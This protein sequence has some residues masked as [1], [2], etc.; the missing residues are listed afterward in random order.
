MPPVNIS[1]A[2]AVD[3]GSIPVDVTQN[4]I[5]DAGVNY[6]VY[7]KFTAPVGAQVIGAWGFSGNTSS[8]Y[9]P[10]IKPYLGPAGAPTQLLNIDCQNKPI[11]FP[12]DVGQEYFLEFV[13]NLD[14]AGPNSLRVRLEI[15][16]NDAVEV[17]NIIVNDDGLKA[18][19]FPCGIFSHLINHT[20][21]R[22]FKN[23]AEGEGGDILRTAPSLGVMA[24]ENHH[25]DTIRIYDANF[26]QTG[27]VSAGVSLNRPRIRTVL[28]TNRWAVADQGGPP[29]IRFLNP[30]ATFSGLWSLTGLPSTLMGFAVNNIES[31][32]YFARSAFSNHAIERYDLTNSIFLSDLAPGVVDHSTL[33]IL[34][35]SNNNIVVIYEDSIANTG[36]VRIYDP[37][38][39]T[40][41]TISFG[42]TVSPFDSSARLAYSNDDPNT[43]WVMLHPSVGITH[44]RE[45]KVADGVLVNQIVS[46]AYTGGMYDGA[47]TV[48]PTARLGNSTSCPFMIVPGT[49]VPPIVGPSGLFVI[50]PNKRND[51]GVAIPTPIFRTGLMP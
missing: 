30:D 21:R 47:E 19:G 39:A 50:T 42:T 48:T 13:K 26:V 43:F 25:D 38:G 12:V 7:Y 2:T 51:N 17:G 14:D 31:I 49:P 33:D 35:L 32:A 16:P 18:Q 24:L 23:I 27:S 41:N 20:V 28:G 1:F 9:R 22:F 34:V 10:N 6:T 8:G 40:V 15:A 46:T 44:F 37:T 36:F 45:Y 5:N 4:N 3:L 29:R 11:Q